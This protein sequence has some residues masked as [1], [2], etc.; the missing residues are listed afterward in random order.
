MIEVGDPIDYMFMDVNSYADLFYSR[1]LNALLALSEYSTEDGS[2]LSLYT[3]SFP[4][5]ENTQ[6]SEIQK[7]SGFRVVLYFFIGIGS[8]IFLAFILFRRGSP[9]KES[10]AMHP[11][12]SR[13]KVNK[14]K[15]NAIL[16]FGGFQVFD[17]E[18][19]DITGNFTPLPK[20]LFLY[21]LLYSL[22]NEKGVSS[23]SLYE[24]FWFDKSVESARNNRAVNIVKL[25]SLLE[26]L[27]SANIS[28]DKGYWKFNFDPAQV[29]IDYFDY[30]Q[31]LNRTKEPLKGDIV[32]L[33]SIVEK[34][35][36]LN[37]TNAEWLDTFKSE[38]SNEIIDAFLKYISHSADD[39][40][41]L[42]HLTDCIFVFDTVSEEALKLQCRLLIRQGK[43]SLAK[44]AYN[45]FIKEYKQLYDE[46]YGLSFNEVIGESSE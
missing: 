44:N 24:T 34:S 4:P 32:R 36:F 13:V 41:F 35:P 33:L 37:N 46:E 30:L 5:Q 16:L 14:P 38:V 26:Q 15:K 25:K 8:L 23:Q 45:R 11:E 20:K 39:A 40:E 18:G 31:I 2:T 28:K 42:L 9:K 1:T 43:H 29:Y 22:R 10:P 21:I 12:L 19:N 17:R 6:A 7:T 3:I 27:D